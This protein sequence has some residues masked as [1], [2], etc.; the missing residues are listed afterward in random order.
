VEQEFAQG[1]LAY[2]DLDDGWRQAVLR[3]P[4]T[5]GS[6]PDHTVEIKRI[7]GALSNLRK[8]HLWGAITDEEFKVE[9]QALHRQRKSLKP[10]SLPQRLPN[11]ERA[12]H[13]LRDLLALWQHSGVTP[14][15]RRDLARE[16]FEELRIREGGLV[17]VKP[18]PQYA[19]LFAYSLWR[20]HQ[21]VGGVCV[22]VEPV[23]GQGD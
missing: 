2:V 11:L 9:F 21:V 23:E 8:Q 1:V 13:L 22:Q 4:A 7:D 5:E 3:A 17:A 14:E 19:P 12:A 16:V 6:E 10:M 20:Q 18:R 15:Q